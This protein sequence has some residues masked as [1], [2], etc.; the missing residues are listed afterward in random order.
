MSEHEQKNDELWLVPF[1]DLMTILALFF[2]SLYGMAQSQR[3]NASVEQSLL[4]IQ[5]EMSGSREGLAKIEVKARE[6]RVAQDIEGMLSGLNKDDV[7]FSVGSQRFR[8]TLA[9]GVLFASGHDELQPEA[10][11]LLKEIAGSL[12]ALPNQIVVEGHTDDVPIGR[13]VRFTSNWDLSVARSFAVIRL[14]NEEGI[15]AEHLSALGFAQFQPV[16]PND[17]DA[18]RARNR[19]IEISLLR[20]TDETEASDAAPAAS[21]ATAPSG[22]PSAVPGG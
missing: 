19:R 13:N 5:K 4:F 8:V 14:F 22:P 17:S 21:T 16:A 6:A 2:L 7:A 9:A 12:K 20:K 11:R 10:V 18:N 3:N 1:S 15:P